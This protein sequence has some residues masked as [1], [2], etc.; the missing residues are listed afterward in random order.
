MIVVVAVEKYHSFMDKYDPV[1]YDIYNIKNN[2]YVHNV[3]NADV[4]YVNW[5]G[6]YSK[7][8]TKASNGY[9]PVININALDIF[10]SNDN[11]DYSQ[12]GFTEISCM[13][14]AEGMKKWMRI[15]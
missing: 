14:N 3:T 11:T 8:F 10:F 12:Y 9:T 7:S 4:T 2:T 13:E 6:E 1:N 5:I 15:S